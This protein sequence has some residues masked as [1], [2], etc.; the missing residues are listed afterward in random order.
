VPIERVCKKIRQRDQKILE[1]FLSTACDD[2]KREV[3]KNDTA[4]FAARACGPSKQ[5]FVPEKQDCTI[6]L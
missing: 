2:A 1:K 5:L 4:L 3:G 6:W